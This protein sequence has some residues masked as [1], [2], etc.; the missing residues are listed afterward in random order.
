MSIVKLKNQEYLVTI[1][2]Y[3]KTDDVNKFQSLVMERLNI[4]TDKHIPFDDN[5]EI[6]EYADDWLD[7]YEVEDE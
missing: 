6:T 3:I 4:D 2:A 5:F 1:S 7:F